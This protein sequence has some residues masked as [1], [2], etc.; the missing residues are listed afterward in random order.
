MR[1]SRIKPSCSPSA[2]ALI[3]AGMSALRIPV[4]LCCAALQNTLPHLPT[5]KVKV[6]AIQNKVL[7]LS[8]YPWEEFV[9]GSLKIK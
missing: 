2:A 6:T 4:S 1:T 7:R 9:N 3:H 8:A 5:H